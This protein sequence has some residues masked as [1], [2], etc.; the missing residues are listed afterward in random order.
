VK[1]ADADVSIVPHN[2]KAASLVRALGFVAAKYAAALVQASN[3]RG[4]GAVQT[5]DW[6]SRR[7]GETGASLGGVREV[8]AAVG[9]MCGSERWVVDAAGKTCARGSCLEGGVDAVEWRAGGMSRRRGDARD[10][11]STGG[12]RSVGRDIVGCSDGL[13]LPFWLAVLVVV[14]VSRSTS[15]SSSQTGSGGSDP[16]CVLVLGRID[17]GRLLGGGR[18]LL[19]GGCR[20]LLISGCGLLVGGRR[21]LVD[22]RGWL[23]GRHR[24]LVGGH[25]L[26]SK[27]LL[28]REEHGKIH[29]SSL[30]SLGWRRVGHVA[31][32]ILII[33]GRGYR[34]RGHGARKGRTVGGN[35]FQTVRVLVAARVLGVAGSERRWDSNSASIEGVVVVRAV[36]RKGSSRAESTRDVQIRRESSACRHR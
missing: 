12:R 11:L 1:L 14:V 20:L 35:P 23:R 30:L 3:G 19:V 36:T 4:G 31:R 25:R 2:R 10:R 5:G 18:G 22:R 33:R 7:A 15:G 13:L 27:I 34:T 21:L 29:R 26:L 24:L 17:G 32:L 8:C 16:V 9:S 28:P 6:S